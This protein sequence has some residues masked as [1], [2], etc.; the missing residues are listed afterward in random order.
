MNVG[1]LLLLSEFLFLKEESDFK[2]VV[3]VDIKVS[4]VKLEVLW[5]YVFVLIK[6]INWK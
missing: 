2:E 4:I 1:L 5:V 6:V 3:L